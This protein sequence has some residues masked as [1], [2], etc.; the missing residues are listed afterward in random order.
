MDSYTEDLK[1]YLH[2]LSKFHMRMRVDTVEEIDI[3]QRLDE[4]VIKLLQL[5]V[6]EMEIRYIINR[7]ESFE[8]GE[9]HPPH[10]TRRYYMPSD[11]Q[12]SERIRLEY[13]RMI[14][15]FAR[16]REMSEYHSDEDEDEDEE[17][18]TA[19]VAAA[20]APLYAPFP[21]DYKHNTEDLKRYLYDLVY[22]HNRMDGESP[23]EPEIYQRLNETVEKL[24]QFGVDNNEI[25]Q[26]IQRGQGFQ[27]GEPHPKYVSRRYYMP[28]DLQ[29]LQRAREKCEYHSDDDEDKYDE[30]YEYKE[31]LKKYL[32]DLAHY[33]IRIHDEIEEEFEIFQR[34]D[35]TVNE[36]L[37]LGVDEHEI[38]HIIQ[39]S[40]E[41]Q[42]G[43]LQP[44]HPRRRYDIPADRL[45]F[46][47]MRIMA[48]YHPDNDDDIEPKIA[49]A[50]S[51]YLYR[52]HYNKYLKYKTKYFAL[53]N[54]K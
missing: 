10:P 22:Y 26:I 27:P 25:R 1:R 13:H 28:T 38:R 17:P 20:P 36:L 12:E 11:R 44:P 29:E 24:Q 23:E 52:L 53:K 51:K 39:R 50:A 14:P 31:K 35:E 41:F 19:A 21:G 48:E 47:R 15:E 7:G 8:S 5:G 54:K 42:P 40:Q 30:N 34:L 16:L 45:E 37:N 4:T 3:F 33:H 43:E 46:A 2:D 49:P 6:D 18:V 9:P 32:H